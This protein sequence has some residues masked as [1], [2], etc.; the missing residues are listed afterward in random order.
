MWL[1]EFFAPWCGHCKNLAPHWAEAATQLKGK[2]KLGALDATV[3]TI[4]AREYGIQGFPTIKFFASG[5]KDSDSAKDYDGGRTT[6]DIVN[7]ALE[8]LAESAPA[9][10]IIQVIDEQTFKETCQDK[11]L[12]VISVLP[13]ILDCQS[14][15]RNDYLQLLKEMGEK[16]KNK[17]WG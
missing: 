10:E 7:W 8:K 2:M 4:K 14:D 16:Y 3:H 17:M 15:C 1:I 13:H 12:C 9:P 6:N 11:P 5:R